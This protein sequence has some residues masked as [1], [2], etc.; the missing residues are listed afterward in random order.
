MIFH[1][2]LNH[3]F[4]SYT[5]VSVLRVLVFSKSGMTGRE[6]ARN[7]GMTPKSAL[8]ALTDLE[9]LSIVKR[10]I[11]GRDHIFTLNRKHYLV[12]KGIIPLLKVEMNYLPDVLNLIKKEL[13][14]YTLGI[15]LFG[16]VA[17]KE[18]DID[19]DLDICFV[20]KNKT[21]KRTVEKKKTELFNVID[22]KYGASLGA[23][24]FTLDEFKKRGLKGQAPVYDIIS[25]GILV[26]GKPIKLLL[27][28]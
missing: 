13:A 26:S 17:R 21:A 9:N 18:E 22:E 1:K 14:Q 25:D 6:V 5:N 7:S 27:Y 20:V 11:G 23:I 24:I 3:V 8:K 10:S 2:V 4:S 12:S 28:G 16:S 19:S 15:F